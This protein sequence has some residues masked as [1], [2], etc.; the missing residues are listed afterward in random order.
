MNLHPLMQQATGLP[1]DI[2][3]MAKHQATEWDAMISQMQA[4]QL[5]DST[6]EEVL[7]RASSLLASI[8]VNYGSIH[9]WSLAQAHVIYRHG[10]RI[11]G[12]GQLLV[13]KPDWTE[14]F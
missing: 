4:L 10:C 1:P 9:G 12:A 14:S 11:F 6:A 7:R 3:E 13:S 8:T 2:V 5:G